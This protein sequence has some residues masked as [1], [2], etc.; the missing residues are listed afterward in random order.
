MI[1]LPKK[2]TEQIL[3]KCFNILNVMEQLDYDE[4]GAMAHIQ[5]QQGFEITS[6]ELY[7]YFKQY[8]LDIE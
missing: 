5:E 8:G 4:L 6:K 2:E 1:T 7:E 3:F